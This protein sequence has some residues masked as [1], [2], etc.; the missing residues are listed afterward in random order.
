MRNFLILGLLIFLFW[1]CSSPVKCRSEQELM[2]N[3]LALHQK[4][5]LEGLMSLFYQKDTPPFVL[6][7]VRR[8][9]KANF[10]FTIT[11]AA[12]AEIPDEKR[13]MVMAGYPYNGKI[14]VPNLAPIKQLV[15][16]YDQSGQPEE[17]RASG[18]SIMFGREG[19]FYYFVL[20][21][22]HEQ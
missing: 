1:G 16:T 9:A 2:D 10:K 5:D 11:S 20:S 17:H 19:E 3:Y 18:S 12:I 22:L 21:K 7:A 6:N 8:A 15:L 14:L 4:K 13:A